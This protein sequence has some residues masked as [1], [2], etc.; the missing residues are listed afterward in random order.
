MYYRYYNYSENDNI[1]KYIQNSYNQNVEKKSFFG[2]VV[3]RHDRGG[4]RTVIYDELAKY[5]EIKSPGIYRK[6]TTQIGCSN[7]DKIKYI[8]QGTYNICPEN[9]TYEGYFTE[10]IFQAFEAGTVP[11]YWAIDLP[12]V[13]IINKN[14]YCFCDVSI[15]EGV[16]KSIRDAVE[17][18]EKFIKGNLFTENAGHH[19]STFYSTLLD[20]MRKFL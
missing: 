9:S 14:K 5:G 11:L 15:R 19:V 6:N 17:C 2:S 13:D 8:S 16:E 4:Q 1:L 7:E 3:A 12:E 20:N 10:K 18:P